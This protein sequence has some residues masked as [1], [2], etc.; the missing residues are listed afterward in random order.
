MLPA[1]VTSASYN[2]GN[3]LT[4]RTAAG[5]TVSPTWDLNGNL[6]NDGVQ[7]YSWD[8]RNRLTA[9]TGLASF[10][11]DSFN[12]RQTATRGGTTTSFLYDGWDVAQ[13]QQGGTS[14]ADLLLG[15]GIDERL[16]RNGATFLNN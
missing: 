15:L 9:I 12:R 2:L 11:Y 14:S 10:I 5:L 4:S 7:T 6:T 1:P 13:E 8:G 3:R 16:S